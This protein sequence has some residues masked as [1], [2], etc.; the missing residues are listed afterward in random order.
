MSSKKR[1]LP[2]TALC[3]AVAVL[4]AGCAGDR[5]TVPLAYVASA[6]N[7]HVQVVDL[8]SGR[9]L[10]KIYCG[11]TPWR[12]VVSP[13]ER[14][15]WVQHWYSATTAVVDLDDHE[16]VGLLPFR[17]PGA[18]TPEGDRFVT[19]NW[20]ESSLQIVD[21]GSLEVSARRPTDAPQVYDLAATDGGNTL[22]MVQLDPMA[23]GPHPRYAYL[24][25]YPLAQEDWAKAV[26]L[27]YGTGQSPAQI[28][29]T[30]DDSFVLTADR[31]TNGLSLINS[32]G[33]GRRI[34]ACPAP[35]TIVLSRNEKRMVVTCFRGEG[36]RSSEVVPY[37]T[38]FTTRPWPTVTQGEPRTVAGALVAGAFSPAG[39]RVYLADRAGNRL[40]ELD[41]GSLEV[42]RELPTGEM[43]VDVKVIAVPRRVRDRLASG[44]SRGRQIAEKAIAKLR[45]S[46]RPFVDLS[47][48]ETTSWYEAAPPPEGAGTEGD[49]AAVGEPIE[50]SR[51]VKYSLKGAGWVRSESEEGTMRLARA[52]HTVSLDGAG[53]FWVSPRQELIS[54]LYSVPNLSVDKAVRLLAGD[55]P[56]SPYLRGG[57]ALD[58]AAE[59]DDEGKRFYV[60]G[61]PPEGA[62]T[63][64]LWIDAASGRPTNLGEQF[65]VF[66]AGGHGGS[67]GFGGV[68]ETKFH[69]FDEV[70]DGVWL[71]TALERVSDGRS[72]AVT[73][74]DVHLDAGLADDLF[75]LDRL[76]G[77][78]AAP[79]PEVVAPVAVEESSQGPGRAVPI[80][81]HGYLRDPRQPH[82][83]YNS[84]PPTSGPRLYDL[85]DW[86]AHSIPVPLELQVHNLEHGGV[87]LQY[88]CPQDCPELAARLAEV[89]SSY[90]TTIVAPYPLMARRI[91]L[92]AW[93]RIDTFEDFDAERITRFIEAY[94]GQDHHTPTGSQAASGDG[95]GHP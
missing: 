89:A 49:E 44:K 76:G 94:V 27:S 50:K 82:P 70:G 74:G 37:D 28:R 20:P 67:S 79:A 38:D 33:D 10:R 9:T 41:A 56:G 81:R 45:D 61:A 90:E 55:V 62:R 92:T 15:L 71:P 95:S 6:A 11:T 17:G 7:N 16:I 29:L 46:S 3:L 48:T 69:H 86:G 23:R 63:S 36:A 66:R 32:H 2:Q 53:H 73:L 25:S 83:P 85:A 24:L 88:N 60:I 43:P 34:P 18:F 47:W 4:L 40:L 21:A 77:A 5:G 12:L 72:L 51:R 52:G 93:G 26:P 87:V 13:G 42:L 78:L 8:G 31:E 14:Q 80:L 19:F 91:A 64:Q 39:D 30:A 22:Y 1:N 59:V 84:N 57:L 68:I 58:V 75:A 65:P 35:Q 54:I